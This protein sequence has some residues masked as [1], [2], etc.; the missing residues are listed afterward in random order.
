[1]NHNCATL[2]PLY[3]FLAKMTAS[4]S[5]FVR[6][7]ITGDNDNELFNHICTMG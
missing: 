3:I 1:M 4:L 7:Y 2:A 6:D 5:D